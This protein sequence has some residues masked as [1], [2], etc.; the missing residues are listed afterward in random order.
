MIT[1]VLPWSQLNTLC[2]FAPYAS[3]FYYMSSYSQLN[4]LSNDINYMGKVLLS[5]VW[6]SGELKKKSIFANIF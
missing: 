5:I 6:K 4:I 3:F 2:A 1:A